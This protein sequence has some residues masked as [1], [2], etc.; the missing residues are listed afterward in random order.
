MVVEAGAS[1]LEPYNGAAAIDE[2]GRNVRCRILCATDPYA[3]V[4][5]QKA[6]GLRPD[7]VAGPATNTSAALDLVEK[8]TGLPGINIIDPDQLPAF[9]DFLVHVLQIDVEA[10]LAPGAG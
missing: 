10:R 6:Y 9:R 8:L 3:V 1:P 7:L 2:L 5:V 4:G